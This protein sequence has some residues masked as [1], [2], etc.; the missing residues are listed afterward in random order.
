MTREEILEKSRSAGKGVHDEREL[1]IVQKGKAISQ[2]VSLTV[3]MLLSLFCM[4]TDGPKLISDTAWTITAVMYAT[5]HLY[6]GIK[7]K[8][9]SIWFWVY[10]GCWRSSPTCGYWVMRLSEVSH[11][12]PTDLKKPH[13]GGP[14]GAQTLSGR[15]GGAGGRVAKHHQL[16]RNGPVQPHRKAGPDPV[17]RI[18]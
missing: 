18:G 2:A 11:E 10:A 16:H 12:R 17:H 5:D 7:L 14:H 15:P 13:Q 8:K 4:I 3:C 6:L 9:P 1:L